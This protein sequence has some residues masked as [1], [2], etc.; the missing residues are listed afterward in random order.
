LKHFRGGWSHFT[1]ASEAVDGNALKIWALSNLG[2]NQ[3]P[4]DNW[5]KEL[6]KCSNRARQVLEGISSRV[7]YRTIP[8]G[9]SCFIWT[10]L[11]LIQLIASLLSAALMTARLKCDE[12]QW[13]SG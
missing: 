1:V 5:P 6:M 4:F 8:G 10:S 7:K 13:R 12:S 11:V 2:S 9:C 3:G